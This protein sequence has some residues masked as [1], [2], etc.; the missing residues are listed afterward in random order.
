MKL[1]LTGDDSGAPDTRT[2]NQ[3]TSGPLHNPPQLACLSDSARWPIWLRRSLHLVEH[4]RKCGFELKRLLDL[5][6]THI[7]IFPV[8]EEARAVVVADELD[9]TLRI[10]LPI[11]RKAFEIF[12]DSE[13]AGGREESHCILGV[14]VEVGVEDALILKV[15][16]PVDLKTCQRK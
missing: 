12:E 2:R 7:G 9:E 16:L 3:V 6:G 5:V 13:N 11:F 14:L 8:F 1:G 10:G 4:V 15:G